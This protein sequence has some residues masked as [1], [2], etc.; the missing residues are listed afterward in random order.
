MIA[1]LVTASFLDAALARL[2]E[3]R[4][5]KTST[6]DELLSIEGELGSFGSRI[7]AAHAF[8]LIDDSVYRDL[9]RISKI[10]NQLAHH[11]LAHDFNDQ[12]LQ[13]WCAE[14]SFSKMPT[15]HSV[16]GKVIFQPAMPK[17]HVARSQYTMAT[18]HYTDLFLRRTAEILG[19]PPPWHADK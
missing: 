17:K 14:L 8:G 4:F 18:I 16:T 12:K 19:L 5:A 7:R 11:H 10:R 13:H 1:A 15:V 9:K 6:A 3:T 2:L